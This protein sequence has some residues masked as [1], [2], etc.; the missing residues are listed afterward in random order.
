[1]IDIEQL[2][3][4]DPSDFEYPIWPPRFIIDMV[5]W[6][7]ETFDPVLLE[8]PMWWKMTIWIDQIFFGPF[9]AFALYAIWKGKSWIRLPAI[10]WAAVMMTNV[11]IILGEEIG[12][13]HASPK[14]FNVLLANA[15][16]FLIPIY[17][18]WRFW[19]SSEPFAAES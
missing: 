6:Y 9:Y 7:G 4:A 12:G 8:R 17:T 2:V 15:A 1:M 5:H 11:T 19:F 18:M 10:I 16:W 14:L 3:I 13:P